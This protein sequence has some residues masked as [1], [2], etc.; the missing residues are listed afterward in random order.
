MM[1]LGEATSS[2]WW[3]AASLML[4]KDSAGNPAC[5]FATSRPAG[6]PSSSSRRRRSS[7]SDFFRGRPAG[8]HLDRPAGRLAPGAAGRPA[9]HVLVAVVVVVV[10][11][12]VV[13]QPAGWAVDLGRPA[14]QPAGPWF[15]AGWLAD[16]EIAGR[17]KLAM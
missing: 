15:L 4:M 14:G 13:D 10:V 12:V 16:R 6:R 17:D 9:G 1:L 7:S 11:V 8:W 5:Y 3:D 2:D